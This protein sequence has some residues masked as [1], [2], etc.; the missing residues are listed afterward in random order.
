MVPYPTRINPDHTASFSY[1]LSRSDVFRF[2]CF[3]QLFT[4]FNQSRR[5]DGIVRFIITYDLKLDGR[6]AITMMTLAH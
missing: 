6:M 1:D 2:S 5:R 4:D 3:F